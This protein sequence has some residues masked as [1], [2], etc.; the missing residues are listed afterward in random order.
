MSGIHAR[1]SPSACVRWSNCTASVRFVETLRASGTVPE[2]SATEW[3]AEGTV[4]HEVREMCLSDGYEPHDFIGHWLTADG[5]TFQVTQKMADYLNPGIDWVRE[6][7]SDLLIE[8]KIDLSPWLP[9]QFGTLDAGWFSTTAMGRVLGLSDL[10]FGMMAVSAEEN[11]QQ[12]LYLLGLWHKLG[13]PDFDFGLINIDQPRAFGPGEMPEDLRALIEAQGEDADLGAGMKFWTIT[14][15]QM[16]EFGD[17]IRNVYNDI[18]TGRTKFAP[19][20]KACTY[21]PAREANPK[22][23]YLGCDAFNQWMMD[24]M[25]GVVDF[26]RPFGN[27]MPDAVE[28][29]TAKRY[30]IV[31]NSKTFIKWLGSLYGA[32]M[33]AAMLG[34]PDPG[35]KLVLGRKGNRVYG[36]KAAVEQVLVNAMGVDA[37][38]PLELVGITDA[39]DILKPGKK[40]KGNPEAWAALEA[41]V[42]QAPAK[43]VLVPETDERPAYAPA[44]YELDDDF[45]DELDDEI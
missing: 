10:K 19:S 36:D 17:H 2:D 8:H 32:S 20:V 23:G 43:P 42:T 5:Y 34:N 26:R 30:E 14:Q 27:E 3:A 13:R 44:V 6:Q 35:S 29:S 21:C 25:L 9:A 40:K 11:E 22:K 31:R 7:S 4:A 18:V 15:A 41:L 28:F 38:K 16:I 24:I 1:L 12:M 33:E 45:D 39:Q 37:Y